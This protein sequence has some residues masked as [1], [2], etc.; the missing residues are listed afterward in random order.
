MTEAAS[1]TIG[2]M[3]LDLRRSEAE[4]VTRVAERDLPAALA[5]VLGPRFAG[6]GVIHLPRL[7]V[8]LSL[9]PRDGEAAL[10]RAWA[11]AFAEAAAAALAAPGAARALVFADPPARLA[12][13][14]GALL[15]GSAWSEPTWCPFAGLKPLPLSVA[16]RTSLA[17]TPVEG[18]AALTR[19]AP[20]DRRH[21]GPRCRPRSRRAPR[22]GA[23]PPRPRLSGARPTPFSLSSPRRRAAGR[24]ARSGRAAAA[25]SRLS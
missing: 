24:T 1:L 4:R 21:A 8:T 17:E 3:V 10:A 22:P 20:A 19:L 25:P 23:G 14:V 5:R 18:R 11:E 13:F 7:E 12:A 2:R 16:L 6:P 15:A 9:D